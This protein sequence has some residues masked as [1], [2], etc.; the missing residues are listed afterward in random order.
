VLDGGTGKMT[1]SSAARGA[2]T[3]IGGAG[4]RHSRTTQDRATG[5]TANLLTNVNNGGDAPRGDT[6]SGIENLSGSRLLPTTLT[7]DAGAN[8]LDGG[9]GNDILTGGAGRRHAGPAE[10]GTIFFRGSRTGLGADRITD[11]A[12]GSRAG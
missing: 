8:V 1:L 9:A 4:D 12:G 5:V 11:F 2:D 6:L 7:G 3:L 10:Q